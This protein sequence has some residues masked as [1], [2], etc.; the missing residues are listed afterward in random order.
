MLLNMQAQTLAFNFDIAKDAE[1]SFYCGYATFIF[2]FNF[3]FLN[4]NQ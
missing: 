2:I 4:I 3:Q 1:R